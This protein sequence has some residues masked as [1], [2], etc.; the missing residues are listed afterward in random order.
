MNNR[1]SLKTWL[2]LFAGIV[3]ISIS[4]I[5]VK[6]AG[7]PGLSSAFYR[8]FIA[9]VCLLP[10]YLR[11]GSGRIS[12]RN[13]ALAF[14]GGVFF[15]CELAFWNLSIL[16]SN[17]TFPTL[18]V[19]LSSIWVAFGATFFLQEK[20]R[21]NHWIG[22][23]LAL[24]G[25]AILIGVEN[26]LQLKINDGFLFAI[27][28]SFFLAFYVLLIKKVRRETETLPVIFIALLGSTITLFAIC[29]IREVPMIGFSAVS[30]FYLLGLGLVTQLGGYFSINYALGFIDST[31]VSLFTLL[32]PILTAVF[33]VFLL[34][35]NFALHQVLGGLVVLSGLAFAVVKF[36]KTVVTAN[37]DAI[38][39]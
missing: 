11:Y 23:F 34:G 24:A 14:L 6:K 10:F 37:E 13:F 12:R 25:V 17:A 21:F 22:N 20:L 19:N 4:A 2:I 38:A 33:A 1:A 9:A 30:W 31:K 7:V 8:V 35:E 27:T 18:I 15:G 26:V 3:C 16:L 28:A 39:D 5:F 36:H 29:A 32:Q